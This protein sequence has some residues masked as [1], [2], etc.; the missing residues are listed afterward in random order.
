M[1]GKTIILDTN[2]WVSYIIKRQLDQLVIAKYDY[3]L[4]FLSC[5]ELVLELTD[6]LQRPKIK[7][8]IGENHSQFIQFHQYHCLNHTIARRTVPKELPQI[9][10]RELI[11]DKKD[12]F[13]F[14]LAATSQAAY[15]VTG[16]R[17]LLNIQHLI[18]H[19]RIISLSELKR[20][21]RK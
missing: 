12:I 17:A 13:L 2:V 9:Y 10:D 19:V 1:R 15:L 16:D 20:A 5:Q 11:P 8:I 14:D 4:A 3:E 18:S 6:V 21:T 7:E